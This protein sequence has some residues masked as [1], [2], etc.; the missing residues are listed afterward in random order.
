ML[1]NCMADIIF[2]AENYFVIFCGIFLCKRTKTVFECAD[3][4]CA[5]TT[6]NALPSGVV[7]SVH[8]YRKLYDD[9]LQ[10]I[11]ALFARANIRRIYCRADSS[12]AVTLIV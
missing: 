9:A 8:T 6:A 2:F 1:S 7:L 4:L 10:D 11:N 3:E 12:F 5:Y